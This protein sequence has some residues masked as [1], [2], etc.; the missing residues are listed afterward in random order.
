MELRRNLSS[1]DARPDAVEG[2][3]FDKGPADRLATLVQVAC[4]G[5][6]PQ[7]KGACKRVI[8][9]IG[10]KENDSFVVVVAASWPFVVDQ[11]DVEETSAIEVH[12][13]GRSGGEDYPTW[14]AEGNNLTT[15]PNA[16]ASR[17][18]QARGL[19][20]KVDAGQ[21]PVMPFATLPNAH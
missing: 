6:A 10:A 16:A 18:G 7:L 11:D 8:E 1:F 4:L 14:W 19:V 13:E 5:G 15:S 21:A 12:N 9:I 3:H 17:S 20:R 2:D